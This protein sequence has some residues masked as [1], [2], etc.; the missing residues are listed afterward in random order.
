LNPGWLKYDPPWVF[1]R[2]QIEEYPAM[3]KAKGIQRYP[4]EVRERAV[5]M[6]LEAL[7][8]TARNEARSAV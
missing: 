2:L 3:E 7:K 8:R 4:R 1:W 6:V 5:R